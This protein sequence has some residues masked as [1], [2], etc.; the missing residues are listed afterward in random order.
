MMESMWF[1]QFVRVVVFYV[2]LFHR[3]HVIN[4]S[5]FT[6]QNPPILGAGDLWGPFLLWTTSSE[7][8]KTLQCVSFP[9][10]VI[11]T[12]FKH[13]SDSHIVLGNHPTGQPCGKSLLAIS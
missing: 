4:T 7:S 1:K 3:R 12:R 11:I 9:N 2:I 6:L 5:N 8:M 10:V 13:M